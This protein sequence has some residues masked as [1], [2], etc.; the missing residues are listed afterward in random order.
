MS[1]TQIT[2]EETPGAVGLV[3]KSYAVPAADANDVMREQLE[4][5][6]EHAGNGPCGCH[7][8]QRYLASKNMLL[9]AFGERPLVLARI[10]A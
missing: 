9:E 1:P 3:R 10:A 8:C 4:F 5:L 6:I 2:P 7:L